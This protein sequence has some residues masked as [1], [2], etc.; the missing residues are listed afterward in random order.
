MKYHSHEGRRVHEVGDI[1]LDKMLSCGAHLTDQ[2]FIHGSPV[3]LILILMSEGLCV[4][5]IFC[6]FLSFILIVLLSRCYYHQLHALYMVLSSGQSSFT[7][8][9]SVANDSRLRLLLRA[10]VAIGIKRIERMP[11]CELMQLHNSHAPLLYLEDSRQLSGS[12]KL[13]T[14]MKEASLS[15][16]SYVNNAS[17]IISRHVEQVLSTNLKY[18]KQQRLWEKISRKFNW[19]Y[20]DDR[21]IE[22][23]QLLLL[24]LSVFETND[25]DIK[26][27][28]LYG[29]PGLPSISLSV[30]ATYA[31]IRAMILQRVP[32]KRF[33]F[34]CT[35]QDDLR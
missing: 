7:K 12:N 20:F 34:C 21:T 17:D 31:E 26:T 2:Y 8:V 28:I 24:V 33:L 35:W 13:C 29:V 23:F 30:T 9:C 1:L 15:N 22:R 27:V 16:L 14:I 25:E 18:V 11:Y 6:L 19:R 32:L 5:S 4:R 3:T 10:R